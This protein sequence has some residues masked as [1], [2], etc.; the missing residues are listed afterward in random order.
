[1]KSY[2]AGSYGP[3]QPTPSPVPTSA[4]QA[5]APNCTCVRAIQYRCV[6]GMGG[7]TP[8][9]QVLQHIIIYIYLIDV[10]YIIEGDSLNTVIHIIYYIQCRDNGWGF[11]W[12]N[13]YVAVRYRHYTCILLLINSRLCRVRAVG[14]R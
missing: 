3:R 1:M 4:T 13:G 5:H 12:S 10:R 2:D 11:D 14:V 9:L 6:G 8:P 7:W